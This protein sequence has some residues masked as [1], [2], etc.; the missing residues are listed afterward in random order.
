MRGQEIE[1]LDVE[2]F[3]EYIGYVLLRRDSF[4]EDVLL[5]DF[6]LDEVIF[7]VDAFDSIV[8]G[9]RVG[10]EDGRRIVAVQ[11]WSSERQ[12]EF[13]DEGVEPFD[14]TNGFRES[15]IFGFGGRECHE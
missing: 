2:R 6:V 13:L 8:H 4:E 5:C 14:F 10:D 7:D 9:G 1:S 11:N 3:C 15:Y 12:I